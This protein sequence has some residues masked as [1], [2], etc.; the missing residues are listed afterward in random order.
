MYDTRFLEHTPWL[1]YLRMLWEQY[2]EELM[3]EAADDRDVDRIHLTSFPRDGVWRAKRIID[4]H[5]GVL[6]AGGVGLGKTFLGG[7][8]LRMS[9]ASGGSV[10]S[11]PRPRSAT[12]PGSGLHTS[13]TSP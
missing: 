1:I 13:S 6:I 12:G 5:H 11:S 10:P 9:S 8:L 4:D 2:G 3:E 7:A